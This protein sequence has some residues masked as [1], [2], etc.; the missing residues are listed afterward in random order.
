MGYIHKQQQSR[1]IDIKTQI[2][3]AFRAISHKKC[4][5]QANYVIIFIERNKRKQKK[6]K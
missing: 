5:K 6:G 1:K 4:T 2:Y 3:A